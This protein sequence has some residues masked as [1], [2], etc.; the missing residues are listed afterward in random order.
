MGIAGLGQPGFYAAAAA[1][2]N[3]SERQ[4]EARNGWLRRAGRDVFMGK[5]QIRTRHRA[6]RA[7]SN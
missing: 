5:L 2:A 4:K 3:R 1:N 7:I 6:A